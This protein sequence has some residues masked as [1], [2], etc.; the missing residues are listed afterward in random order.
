MVRIEVGLTGYRIHVL[1][2]PLRANVLRRFLR[3]FV[4]FASTEVL[5]SRIQE[6]TK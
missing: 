2:A 1:A 4:S 3:N 6:R 5:F